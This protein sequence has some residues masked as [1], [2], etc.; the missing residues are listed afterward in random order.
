MKLNQSV[1][2]QSAKSTENCLSLPTNRSG[3]Q[4][5][6]GKIALGVLLAAAA[7]SLASPAF[8]LVDAELAVGQRSGTWKPKNSES[9][10]ISSQTI[11]MAA[12]VDPIPLIPVSF[13]IRVISDSYKTTIADHGVKSLTSTAVVPEITGWLPLGS[14]KPFARL[15]YTA[16]S[17]YKGTV[18]VLSINGEIVETSTGPRM[19]A[20]V[21]YSPLPFVSFTV[22]L[23]HST[24]T[25]KS[26]AITVGAV[27]VD[28]TSTAV[29]TNAILL[30]AKVGI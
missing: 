1:R 11:Q 27:T 26:K 23:E 6:Q 24:E 15:G 12:H 19:A 28:A 9:A 13:G 5:S 4:S 17:A 2:C 22:A 21:E 10:T 14:I 20:G 25:L 3:I 18:E 8:A 29:L 30:G 7:S 16:V